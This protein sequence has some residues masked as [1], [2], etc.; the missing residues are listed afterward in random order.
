MILNYSKWRKLFEELEKDGE[1]K[2]EISSKQQKKV[3]KLKSNLNIEDKGEDD[4]AT[5]EE[6]KALKDALIQKI[7]NDVGVNIKFSEKI[8]KINDGEGI[9]NRMLE[10]IIYSPHTPKDFYK[11]PSEYR[12]YIKG[13]AGAKNVLDRYDSEGALLWAPENQKYVAANPN[14]I[15]WRDFDGNEKIVSSIDEIIKEVNIRNAQLYG[16]GERT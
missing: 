4:A 8:R 1:P 9:L 10:S 15:I 13:S 5:A 12:F 3:E 7:N 11:N 2:K 16:D 14:E 6:E